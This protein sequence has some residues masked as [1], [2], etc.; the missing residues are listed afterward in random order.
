MP[1]WPGAQL[2]LVEPHLAFALLK[3]GLDGPAH[4]AHAH[5][6][7]QGGVLRRVA[8]VDLDLWLGPRRAVGAPEQHPHLRPGNPWRVVP[9]RRAAKTATSGP[10][11]PSK[12]R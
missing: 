7:R 9:A 8:Q 10:L 4:P 11:L 3:A 6:L 2:I 12:I 5:Q 1:A